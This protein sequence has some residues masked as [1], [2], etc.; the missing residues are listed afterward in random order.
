MYYYHG[1]NVKFDKFDLSYFNTGLGS[2]TV[3]PVVHL[4]PHKHYAE[5]A[6]KELSKKSCKGYVYTVKI[7]GDSDKEYHEY[8]MNICLN[9]ISIIEIINIE[10]V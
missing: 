5:N 2:S 4:T 6:A 8:M 1:T 10:E 9:N 7:K 3:C